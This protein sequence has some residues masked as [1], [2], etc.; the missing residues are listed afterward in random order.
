MSKSNKSREGQPPQYRI[1]NS[2]ADLNNPPPHYET[3]GYT[4]IENRRS[5]VTTYKYS[6]TLAPIIP[7]LTLLS[8][9]LRSL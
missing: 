5:V 6:G 9:I 8:E 1:S 7:S 3:S 4:N 2:M